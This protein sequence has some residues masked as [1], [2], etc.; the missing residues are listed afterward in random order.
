MNWSEIKEAVLSKSK[1]LKEILRLPELWKDDCVN[2]LRLA[3]LFRRRKEFENARTVSNELS[4]HEAS[5][6]ARRIFGY[7][8]ADIFMDEENFEAAA[9][10]YRELIAAEPRADAHA[11]VAHANLGLALW[12]LNRH[13]EALAAYQAALAINPNNAIAWRG[14]G[15]MQLHHKKFSE[16]SLCFRE[17]LKID[18]R[19]ADAF[20]GLSRSEYERDEDW[21]GAYTAAQECLEIDPNNKRA[22]VVLR[23]IDEAL[24]DD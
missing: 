3:N 12:E 4:R 8:E 14:A 15:E 9:Q 10:I 24:A 19:Y 20:G 21:A 7:L 22:K 1:E 6:Q 17:A 5:A 16:A 2:A 11:D 18:K 13:E 23:R